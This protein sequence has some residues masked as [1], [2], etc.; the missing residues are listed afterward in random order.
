MKHSCLDIYLDLSKQSLLIPALVTK[1]AHKEASFLTDLNQ[2]LIETEN[3]MRRYQIPGCADV[4]A[5]RSKIIAVAYDGEQKSSK[6]KRQLAV[7]TSIVSDA[8]AVLFR[9]LEPVH[10]RIEQAR[11]AIRQLLGVAYQTSMIH[12]HEGFNQMIQLL[13]RDF[14]AHEQLKGA[15][16]TIL[17]LIDQSDAIRLLAEE[18]DISM[19]NG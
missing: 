7:A 3:V 9:E 4:A 10:M 8:Q 16:A 13:W 1:A 6:R 5:L 11:S 18:I 12:Q 17:V 15:T 14:M 19:L 2:W